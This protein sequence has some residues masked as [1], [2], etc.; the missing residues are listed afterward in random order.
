MALSVNILKSS[1]MTL[2]LVFRIVGGMR[3]GDGGSLGL[4]GDDPLLQLLQ[5]KRL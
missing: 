2:L 5:R 3:V 1:L 4:L